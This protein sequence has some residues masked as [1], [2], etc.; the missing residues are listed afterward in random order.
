MTRM[1]LV[2]LYAALAI[3]IG[4]LARSSF[5]DSARLTVTGDTSLACSAQACVIRLDPGRWTVFT[6]KKQFVARLHE[7][8]DETGYVLETVPAP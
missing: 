5:G 7:I 1:D 6:P 8:D 3:I 2:I 4:F